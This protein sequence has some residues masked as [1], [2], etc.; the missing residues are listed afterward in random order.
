MFGQTDVKYDL[1]SSYV[2]EV[3]ERSVGIAASGFEE[4]LEIGA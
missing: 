4:L 2:S 3:I 1:L